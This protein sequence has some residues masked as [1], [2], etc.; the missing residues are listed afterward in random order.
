M[1]KTG[2]LM[3]ATVACAVVLTGV[4]SAQSI[5]AARTAYDEGRFLE[6]AELGA[7]L[8]TSEG[9][10]LA[11]RSLGVHGYYLGADDE[12][13]AMFERAVELAR[14]AIRLDPANPNGHLEL[15]HTLGRH[16]QTI[17]RARAIQEGHAASVRDA[18]QEALRL[19]P[20]LAA[21]HLSL[22]AWHAEVVSAG[23]LARMLYGGNERDSLAH[24]R[25]AQ[26]LAP[27]E[28]VVLVE[29]ALGLLLLDEDDYGELARDLLQRA[30]DMPAK[31]AFDRLQDERAV[32]R[33]AALGG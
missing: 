26:E 25:R 28:K 32:E 23:F 18:V 8:G 7:A 27:D 33:L 24:F 16:A 19:D 29:Q 1:F 22:A 31:N 21:A 20:D 9:Y 3:F 13:Q 11:A 14:E 2:L 15:G 6:A 5:E 30:I 17:G 10:A 12:K 4:A